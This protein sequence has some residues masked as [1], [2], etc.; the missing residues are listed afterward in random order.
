MGSSCL[1]GKI[2]KELA[3]ISFQEMES[4]VVHHYLTHVDRL[5]SRWML[6]RNLREGKQRKPPDNNV[7]VDESIVSEDYVAMLPRY[8]LVERNAVPFELRTVDGY[9]SELLLFRRKA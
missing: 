4:N 7:G 9:N 5:S 1:P 3:G 8:E 2:M 6:L